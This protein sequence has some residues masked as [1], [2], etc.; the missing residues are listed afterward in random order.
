MKT[1]LFVLASLVLCLAYAGPAPAQEAAD[2]AAMMAAW[3]KAMTPGPAHQELATHAG[4]WTYTSKMWMQPDAP[5]MES[6][7]KSK[8]EAIMGGRY[9]AENVEGEMMGMPMKGMSVTGYNNITQMYESTWID[10]MGTGI[11]LAK[12][13]KDGDTLTLVGS[14]MDPMGNM[15]KVKMVTTFKDKD[16]YTFEYYSDTPDGT[17]MAKVMEM[18]YTRKGAA[19]E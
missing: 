3:Q 1:K 5:P 10:N 2:E 11:M 16:H 4:D 13:T 18:A 15:L 7:G 14:T 6:T 9:I 17:E 19:S 12:G 8:I